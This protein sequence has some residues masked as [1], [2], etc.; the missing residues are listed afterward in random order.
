MNRLQKNIESA[1]SNRG[2]KVINTS[3]APHRFEFI[4]TEKDYV[5]L[6][7]GLIKLK[8]EQEF[9]KSVR[10]W[11]WIDE[12]PSECCDIIEIFSKPVR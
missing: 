12:D 4:G 6:E 5:C 3:K 2:G 10:K 9:W 1:F 11:E 8:R 7:L